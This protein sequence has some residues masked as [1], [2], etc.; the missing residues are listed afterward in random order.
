[1]KSGSMSG[2]QS[3][4]ARSK[5]RYF[6]EGAVIASK[7]ALESSAFC[8]RSTPIVL[9]SAWMIWNVRST[10]VRSV[11]V[12]TTYDILCPPATRIPSGPFL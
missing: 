11:G 2:T 3:H 4:M 5:F 12:M 10:P 6:V 9:K 8:V 1:M 7:A